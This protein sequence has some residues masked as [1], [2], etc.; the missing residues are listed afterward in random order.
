M[1]RMYSIK[2]YVYLVYKKSMDSK[3]TLTLAKLASIYLETATLYIER[4]TRPII[5]I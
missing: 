4:A 3:K 5:I 1:Y 2:V